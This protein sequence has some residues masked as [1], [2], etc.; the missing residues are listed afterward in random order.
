MDNDSMSFGGDGAGGTPDADS[1]LAQ[2]PL[3][4]SPP[5]E[6][7]QDEGQNVDSMHPDN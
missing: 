1:I 4:E 7:A 2:P 5:A 6:P 3:Q